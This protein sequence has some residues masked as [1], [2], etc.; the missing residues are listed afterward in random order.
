[1]IRLSAHAHGI[2]EKLLYAICKIESDFDNTKSQY[3]HWYHWTFK[4]E[5]FLNGWSIYDERKFQK[6]KWGLMQM[7]GCDLR[8][9]GYTGGINDIKKRI[10]DQLY[11]G[12]MY[13]KRKIDK[14]GEFLGIISYHTGSPI[15]CVSGGYLGEEYYEKVIDIIDQQLLPQNS[16][17]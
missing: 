15:K 13:L 8:E 1:M 12:C 17:S 16:Q 10:A 9:F 7:R 14:Y 2:D 6:T 4:P 5:I 3:D 11:Y